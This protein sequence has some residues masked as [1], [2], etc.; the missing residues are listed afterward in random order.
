MRSVWDRLIEPVKPKVVTAFAPPPVEIAPGVWSLERR[1]RM[2]GGPLL[3]SRATVIRLPTGGLLVVSPPPVEAGGLEALDALGTIAEVLVPNSFH[4]LNA[5]DFLARYPSATLRVVPGLH[6]R[7]PSLPRGEVLAAAPASWGGAME[8]L[9]LGPVRGIAEAAL[10]HRPS[11]T[12]ILT[13]LAFNMVHFAS[14]FERFAWRLSGVPA[15]FGPSR[16]G[17]I[18]LL[19]DR[20]VAAPFLARVLEWPFERVLV[21]HGEP[22]SDD[23]KANFHRAFSGHLPAPSS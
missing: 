12:L 5:P 20:S 6:E 2:P 19:K 16:T 10:F 15:G 4:Y 18:F 23:A 17:R 8:H 22:L 3:P 7:V 14:A 21:A 13:D 9:V 1:L 11:A